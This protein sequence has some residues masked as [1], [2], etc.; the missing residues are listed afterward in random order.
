M[1]GNGLRVERLMKN[2][3]IFLVG[4]LI[5]DFSVGQSLYNKLDSTTHAQLKKLTLKEQLQFDTL[6]QN[7]DKSGIK[8]RIDT[9][10]FDYLF[11]Q[12]T[13]CFFDSKSEITE[14]YFSKG[15]TIPKLIVV[16]ERKV[17]FNSLVFPE[18]E[19]YRKKLNL[20][21]TFSPL[22]HSYSNTNPIQVLPYSRKQAYFTGCVPLKNNRRI[23][24]KRRI[25]E[26][27]KTYQIQTLHTKD[28]IQ[29]SF[30][31][32]PRNPSIKPFNGGFIW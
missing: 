24:K 28:K 7:R 10:E 29:I 15:D 9:V 30:Q 18:N 26:L 16:N 27:K 14:L 8:K 1:L 22:L 21:Y 25:Q 12:E 6:L 13:Y 20:K 19:N 32:P 31:I 2:T 23:F 11:I 5:S 17:E 3:F 4:L